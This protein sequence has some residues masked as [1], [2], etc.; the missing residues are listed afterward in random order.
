[1]GGMEAYIVAGG[2]DG[3]NRPLSS[4][5]SWSTRQG[6]STKDLSQGPR[7]LLPMS[8]YSRRPTVRI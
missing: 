1:M 5:E 3:A 2:L 4:V 6:S 8:L 7:I